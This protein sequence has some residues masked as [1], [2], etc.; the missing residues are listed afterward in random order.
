[1]SHDAKTVTLTALIAPT[2]SANAGVQRTNTTKS[3]DSSYT[4]KK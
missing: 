4:E 2:K 1:M 3:F